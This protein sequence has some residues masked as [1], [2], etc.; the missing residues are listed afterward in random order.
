LRAE[1]GLTADGIP[2]P[3]TDGDVRHLRAVAE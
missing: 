3:R 1:L 2:M